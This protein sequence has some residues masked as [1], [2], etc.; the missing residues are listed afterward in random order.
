MSPLIRLTFPLWG[1]PT[2]MNRLPRGVA[3]LHFNLAFLKCLDRPAVTCL[4]PALS[5][6]PRHLRDRESNRGS[7]PP[8]DSLEVYLREVRNGSIGEYSPLRITL[9]PPAV[10]DFR[11]F[12][13]KNCVFF[14]L[15][16]LV[17]SGRV[18][19]SFFHRSLPSVELSRSPFRVLVITLATCH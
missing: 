6:P 9:N 17:C 5:C 2:G 14:P 11:V 10:P 4:P 16:S 18:F 1:P 8:H 3:S 19:W 15:S 13:L 7:P 12:V